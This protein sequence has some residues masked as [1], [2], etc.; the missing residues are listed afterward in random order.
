MIRHAVVI[1]SKDRSNMI[2]KYADSP[3][4]RFK[5]SVFNTYLWVN[6][7]EEYA[8]AK[9]AGYTYVIS[10]YTA[11]N[12]AETREHI[13]QWAHK[14]K[15]DWLFMVDDD[16]RFFARYKNYASLPVNVPETRNMLNHLISICTPEHPLVSIRERFMIN[17]CDYAY[18]KNAKI[19]RVY[20][21]HVP[22]FIEQGISFLYKGMKVF[23]DK[24]VQV[25]LNEKGYRTITSVHFAQSTRDS[26]NANGGCAEY[27]T[28]PETERCVDIFLKDFPKAFTETVKTGYKDGPVRYVKSTLKNYLNP[29][30]L[31]YVPSSEMESS[32]SDYRI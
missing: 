32:L 15:Y 30:E 17:Q 10:D 16:V 4:N 13:L 27:R 6:S 28:N 18:E 11:T 22:T 31:K 25:L 7:S 23:E 1:P 14:N 12:I 2:A 8:Y 29:G 26:S 9:V 24:L 20:M 21:I 19:I 3:L 5:D